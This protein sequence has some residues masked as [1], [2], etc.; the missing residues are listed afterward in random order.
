V[1]QETVIVQGATELGEQA[2]GRRRLIEGRRLALA[3]D[4]L[5]EGIGA[6]M[7]DEQVSKSE[8]FGEALAQAGA[9]SARAS[10]AF[11][12]SGGLADATDAARDTLDT[13]AGLASALADKS[14]EKDRFAEA[15]QQGD[16]QNNA[17]GG[18]GGGGQQDGI[19]PIAEL[20]LLRDLQAKLGR[21]TARA[22]SDGGD[23]SSLPALRQAQERLEA[24]AGR[25]REAIMNA[26]GGAPRITPVEPGATEPGTTEPGTTEPEGTR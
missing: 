18:G 26:E 4:E 3:Q 11:R 22:M 17:G 14:K 5:A 12:R 8:I 15:R 20:K 10:E 13:L 21:R 7:A 19:L 23:R 1:A 25:L 9:S 2:D 24:M 6:L 16:Q